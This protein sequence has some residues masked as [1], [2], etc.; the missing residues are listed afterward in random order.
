MNSLVA[1]QPAGGP[2][3][4]LLS[5]PEGPARAASTPALQT[6]AA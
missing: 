1:P 6:A 3:P 5:L 2:V 4:L